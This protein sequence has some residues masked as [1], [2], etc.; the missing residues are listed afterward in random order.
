MKIKFETE[1]TKIVNIKL[2]IEELIYLAAICGRTGGSGP[3]SAIFSKI[4]HAA[5]NAGA[6]M[7]QRL[8]DVYNKY[9]GE[10]HPKP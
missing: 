9:T 5:Y 3:D 7:R 10:I 6:D 8:F 2:S 4:Y 1:Q